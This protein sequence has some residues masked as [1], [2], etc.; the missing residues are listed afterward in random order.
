MA[1]IE[2]VAQL[3]INLKVPLNSLRCI[4]LTQMFM[5]ALLQTTFRCYVMQFS[6]D[7]LQQL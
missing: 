2:P 7:R 4:N 6:K 1:E 3:P 5:N